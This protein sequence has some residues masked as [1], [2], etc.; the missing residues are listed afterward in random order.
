MKT[1]EQKKMEKELERQLREKEAR[2]AEEKQKREQEEAVAQAILNIRGQREGFAALVKEY[3][4]Y[5]LEAAKL[6]RD[7]FVTELLETIVEIEE[8]N[9]NMQ[10]LEIK[11][12]AAARTAQS[13][14]MI[15]ELSEA[16]SACKHLFSQNFDFAALG[17]DF[18]SVMASLGTAREQFRQFRTGFGKTNSSPVFHEIFGRPNQVED[19]KLKSRLEE[20][21]KALEARLVKATNMSSVSPMPAAQVVDNQDAAKIDAIARM[22]DDERRK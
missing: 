18:S 19:T 15:N 12:T 11:I 20:K 6:G 14:Q 17:K 3:E 8:F 16:L 21:K 1:R 5:A 7:E 2:E 10:F 22:L 13:F 9:E 4:D